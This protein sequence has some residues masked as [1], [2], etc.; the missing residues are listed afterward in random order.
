MCVCM[1][2]F[3]TLRELN[4]YRLSLFCILSI[5]FS[6]HWLMYAK[7]LISEHIV[8]HNTLLVSVLIRHNI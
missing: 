4:R 3:I 5:P 1:Y 8:L 6:L 7:F 2:V